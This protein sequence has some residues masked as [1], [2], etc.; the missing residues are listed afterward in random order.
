MVERALASMTE[1]GVPQVMGETGRLDEIGIDMEA[2]MKVITRGLQP[3][4]N[5]APDLSDFQR[6]GQTRSIEV[7]FSAPEDLCLALE[8]AEGGGM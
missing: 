6:M 1:G 7:I 4:T 2:I 3:I 5:A 8:G